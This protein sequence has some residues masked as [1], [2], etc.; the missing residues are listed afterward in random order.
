MTKLD[1]RNRRLDWLAAALVLAGAGW[2][3]NEFTPLL[4]VYQRALGVGSSGLAVLFGVYAVGLIAGLVV[5]GPLSDARGWR[6][7]VMA[8]AMLSVLGGVLMVVGSSTVG[9]LGAGRTVTGLANGFAFGAG[10]VW[11]R[12]LSAAADPEVPVE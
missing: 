3:S 9:V 6:G 4:P 12:E 5:A 10:T 2:G 7:V 11:L 1:V 8:G